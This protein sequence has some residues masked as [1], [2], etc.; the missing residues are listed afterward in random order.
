MILN[1]DGLVPGQQVDFTTLKKVERLRSASVVECKDIIK[2]KPKRKANS[3]KVQ[4][5]K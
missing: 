2:P 4:P 5:A 3:A 1:E